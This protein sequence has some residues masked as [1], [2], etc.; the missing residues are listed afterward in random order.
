MTL[1]QL[2]AF[3]TVAKEGSFTKTGKILGISQPSVSALVIGLQKELNV[4]L[5][6]KLGT[7]P[8]LTEAGRRLF[9]LVN[10]ALATF[11]KI[12]DEMD[13][14]KGL[15]KCRLAVGGS[16]FAGSTLLPIVVRAFKKSFPST[17]IKVTIEGS[18][19][20]K[21]KLLSGDLDVALLGQP[22]RASLLVVKPF[23]EERIVVVIAPNHPLARRRSVP[24]DL[25]AKEPLI[26]EARGA[27]RDK[28]EALYEKKGFDFAPE[29]VTNTIFGSR[30]AIKTAVANGIGIAFISAHQIVL[31]V[32][33]GR[34]KILNV[35]D[36]GL[37]RAM[38]LA[39]H[40]GR[41]SPL[42]QRFIDFLHGY[43]ER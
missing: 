5:F 4:R 16:G 38:Y 3:T 24:L 13:Q 35:P 18:P 6:E 2:K 42:L 34:L 28:V 33:A 21:E 22:A 10:S 15:K 37:T 12:P 39:F 31:D 25:V 1:W 17:D 8:H 32:R 29:L 11:E 9:E 7:K 19:V 23:R 26:I 40:K 20:L 14:V 41:Q 27:T 43:K 30:E 36:L